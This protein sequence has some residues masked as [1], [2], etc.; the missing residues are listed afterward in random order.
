MGAWRK[1]I[2]PDGLGEMCL[3]IET[4]RSGQQAEIFLIIMGISRMSAE[5]IGALG[6]TSI[7]RS[8]FA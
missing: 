4:V 3:R 8:F 7:L 1:R 2:G 5:R 6:W